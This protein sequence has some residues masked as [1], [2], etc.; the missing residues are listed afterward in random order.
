VK[1]TINH[2]RRR[3]ADAV[4]TRRA[5]LGLAQNELVGH[6]G[7]G[8]LT[9]R[10]IERGEPVQYRERTI[11]QLET[12]L[13]WKNG[14]VRALL[15][16]TADDDPEAWICQENH[17]QREVTAISGWSRLAK[18]VRARRLKLNFTQEELVRRGGPSH[19][20]IRNIEQGRQTSYRELTFAKLEQ[21]LG[22]K[23]GTVQSILDD[24][25]SDDPEAWINHKNHSQTEV[26]TMDI[27]NFFTTVSYLKAREDVENC[28]NKIRHQAF[29]LG[30]YVGSGF[31]SEGEIHQKLIAALRVGLEDG[32][33]LPINVKESHTA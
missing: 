14:V 27:S 16:D 26:T 23:T 3:L 13:K 31:L 8:D 7:P 32:S 21:V 33:Q 29:I 17:S 24:T 9:V 10:K 22:W 15:N 11:L 6:G 30:G 5:Q 20:T 28:L 18:E 1:T 12:A 4:R 19:Q 25:A 2:G